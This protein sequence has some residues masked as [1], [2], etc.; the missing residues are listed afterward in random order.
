[1]EVNI[2]STNPC[3]FLTALVWQKMAVQPWACSLHH[4]QRGIYCAIYP[5]CLY[6][7][8][9]TIR[10]YIFILMIW[11]CLVVPF[12]DVF[13]WRKFLVS[14]VNVNR[15]PFRFWDRVASSDRVTD[16]RQK[17]DVYKVSY[18]GPADEFT[19][20]SE[21]RLCRFV[22]CGGMIMIQGRDGKV[23]RNEM[24]WVGHCMDR[25]WV[26]GAMR[27]PT[28]RSIEGTICLHNR[29]VFL[30]K[31]KKHMQ[32]VDSSRTK[33]IHGISSFQGLAC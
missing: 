8:V 1:M 19:F 12:M 33:Y 30:A 10:M 22:F 14:I 7:F 15:I 18:V 9:I 24:R 5:V 25:E 27:R 11:N 31:L 29:K 6:I 21:N 20:S 32:Y 16:W 28:D 2:F 26:D 23:G 4:I 13:L 3:L 17:E